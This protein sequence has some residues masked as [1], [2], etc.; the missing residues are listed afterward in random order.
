MLA[1]FIFVAALLTPGYSHMSE[2]IS[3]L[4]AQGRPHPEVM[5]T[6]FIV[7]GLLVNGFAYGLYRRLQDHAG[8]RIVWILLT[9][10]GIGV[11]LS[12]IF[13]DGSKAPGTETNLEST[14]HSV[15][16]MIG[17]LALIAGMWVFARLVH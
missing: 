1:L 16:A 4:G 15:F 8:A 6:G 7:F 9:I 11:S 10:Y 14:L 17:F 3:Q 5:S 2:T 12:G 13:Q